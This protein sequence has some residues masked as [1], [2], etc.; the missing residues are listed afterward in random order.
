TYTGTALGVGF[1]FKPESVGIYNAQGF[2]GGGLDP[3][4]PGL[5]R[6]VPGA[7]GLSDTLAYW[8]HEFRSYKEDHRKR[9]AHRTADGEWH[10]AGTPHV[11]TFHL[12]VA[13]A[14]TMD[15]GRPLAGGATPAFRLA[16]TSAPAPASNL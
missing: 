2:Y 10:A 12:V 4:A 16:I 14:A 3:K 7:G 13:I 15:D 11:D 6:I 8:R 5:F 1:R 9:D